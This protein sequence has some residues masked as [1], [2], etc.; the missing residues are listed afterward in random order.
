MNGFSTFANNELKIGDTI[1][2]M[3]PSG[4][5]FVDV[6]ASK[7]NNYIAF[8][9]G[10]GITP[11]LSIIKTHLTLEPECTFKLFYLNRMTNSIIFK[12]EIEQ[13]KNRFFERF[14]QFYFLT[15]C[16]ETQQCYFYILYFHLCLLNWSF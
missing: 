7:Q 11:L 10:S 15:H 13:L 4:N 6:D 8:A 3:E 12:E 1:E 14:H 2:I 9:A 16:V 5:F